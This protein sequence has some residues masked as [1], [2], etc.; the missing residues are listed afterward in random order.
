MARVFTSVAVTL[1]AFG[2][3]VA[4]AIGFFGSQAD[5]SEH[6]HRIAILIGCG[7]AAFIA[8]NLFMLL[9][10]WRLSA[11]SRGFVVANNFLLAV[12]FG[13]DQWDE[14]VRRGTSPNLLGSSLFVAFVISTIGAILIQANR[15]FRRDSLQRQR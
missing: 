6:E 7:L 8:I 11:A 4:L 15:P 14:F 9:V 5:T 13:R 2:L 1:N 12:W 10:D 3:A